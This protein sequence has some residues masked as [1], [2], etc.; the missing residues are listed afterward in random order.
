MPQEPDKKLGV[1][2]ESLSRVSSKS[3]RSRTS[4]RPTV[5]P[6]DHAGLGWGTSLGA[7]M[8]D[9][10]RQAGGVCFGTT[11]T[12]CAEPVPNFI[13]AGMVAHFEHGEE[14]YEEPSAARLRRAEGPPLQ[15]V[16]DDNPV[17]LGGGRA[18]NERRERAPP[19]RRALYGKRGMRDDQRGMSTSD[20]ESCFAD[21]GVRDPKAR[22][23][24]EARDRRAR[25]E[26]LKQLEDGSWKL[27]EDGPLP[28][29][30]AKA[31]S[32]KKKS[33]KDA[34]AGMLEQAQALYV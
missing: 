10:S 15:A 34:E 18:A 16:Q 12:V 3:R 2:K 31:A 26:V 23:I 5:I 32:A 17:Q 28:V 20:G 33:K 30:E 21:W 11:T 13:P 8:G 24:E 4:L 6:D 7:R 29:E 9:A 1:A 27:L 25:R 14:V 19:N 22:S